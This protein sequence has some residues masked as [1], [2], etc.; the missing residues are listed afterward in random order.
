MGRPIKRKWFT[1]KAGSVA[2][3]LNLNVF[4][5]S[6]VAEVI[7]RQKG[8]GVYLTAS[9]RQKLK[10]GVPGVEGDAQLTHD[11]G[12]GG[13]VKSVRK[14]AQYRLYYFDGTSTVWRDKDGNVVGTFDPVLT[15]EL[16]EPGGPTSQATGTVVAGGVLDARTVASVTITDSGIGYTSAPAVTFKASTG[17]STATGTAIIDGTGAVTSVTVDTAGS[18]LDVDLPIT[19]SFAAP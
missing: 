7:I 2:G 15:P 5:G 8:T 9:G 12:V 10:D 1:A 13:G 16:V 3:N 19:V 6:V 11:D 18:Y 17:A 14:I 4:T